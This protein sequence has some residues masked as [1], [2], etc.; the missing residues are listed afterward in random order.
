MDEPLTENPSTPGLKNCEQRYLELM[1]SNKFEG[2]GGKWYP[3]YIPVLVPKEMVPEFES[4]A[5]RSRHAMLLDEEGVQAT[6]NL[7][8]SGII[9]EATDKNELVT[10]EDDL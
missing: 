2:I 5:S 9:K 4:V 10:K 6:V 8:N 7:W 3:I 1:V